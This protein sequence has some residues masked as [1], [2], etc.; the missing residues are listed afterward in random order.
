MVVAAL[1]T[2]LVAAMVT[3]PG[4]VGR[5]ARTPGPEVTPG[6][7]A[8]NTGWRHRATK[9]FRR[10]PHTVL[11][12]AVAAWA[13]DLA[14]SL[15]HGS[16]LHAAL[17]HTVPTDSVVG[18]HSASLRH[19]LGRGVTVAEACDEW[20]VDLTDGPGGF[21]LRSRVGPM[22]GIELLATT[23]A[24]LAAAA[25]LGGTAAAPLDRLAVMMR[26]RASDD[27]E[28]AA[29]SAQSKMSAKVLTAVPVAV[30]ALLLLTD[31]EVRGVITS[32]GGGTVVAIGLGLNAVG[33]VWMKRIAGSGA[34]TP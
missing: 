6:A 15:R 29:Q 26:Q 14:R 7:P 11:P 5:A 1:L 3:A 28:R 23:A 31:A 21:S 27:L 32:V 30:L 22:D 2:G 24:V 17:E 13:D 19:W 18:R 8:P 16:T 9:R 12:A 10:T 33:A 34:G 4:L 25:T 20:S